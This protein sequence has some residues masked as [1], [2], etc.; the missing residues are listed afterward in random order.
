M[1][2]LFGVTLL[3]IHFFI[4]KSEIEANQQYPDCQVINIYNLYV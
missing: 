3:I 1:N 4:Y 2:H